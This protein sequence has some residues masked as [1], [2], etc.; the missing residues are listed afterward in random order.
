MIEPVEY[1]VLVL[2]EVVESKTEGGIYLP[3]QAKEKNQIAQ[4]KAQVIAIGGNAFEEW[5]GAIPQVGDTVYIAK[6]AG[7][8]IDR[9]GKQYRLI[10]DKDIAAIE[11]G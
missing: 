9:D 8:L 11:R 3:E 6:Y 4:C 2:P 10:N 5:K 7:Y 1:K